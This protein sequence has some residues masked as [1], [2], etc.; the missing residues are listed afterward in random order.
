MKGYKV[1]YKIR[2]SRLLLWLMIV[3]TILLVATIGVFV[4]LSLNAKYHF[5]CVFECSEREDP[6]A[7][8]QV[9]P[10]TESSSIAAVYNVSTTRLEISR[11]KAEKSEEPTQEGITRPV[12]TQKP[13]AI[14]EIGVDGFISSRTPSTTSTNFVDRKTTFA[15]KTRSN[16]KKPTT[17][18]RVTPVKQHTTRKPGVNLNAGYIRIRGKISFKGKA[19]KRFPR[20]SRLVVEFHDDRYADTPSIRLGKTTVDLSDYRRGKQLSYTITCKRPKRSH[21]SFSV[22][23]VLNVGWKSKNKNNW[24]RKGDFLTDTS[25]DVHINNFKSLYDRNIQLVKYT[26]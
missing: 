19:P 21:M 23:A 3:V 13:T 1:D 17:A 11:P 5:A 8:G 2:K 22:S 24:I 25:F 18:Y 15:A 10:P 20:N 16:V 7:R 26:Y 4:F 12:T 9:S 6:V 14:V